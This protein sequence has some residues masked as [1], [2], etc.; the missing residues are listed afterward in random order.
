MGDEMSDHKNREDLCDGASLVREATRSALER[1]HRQGGSLNRV[2]IQ[3]DQGFIVAKGAQGED[4]IK[5]IA[6]AGRSLDRRLSEEEAQ[7]LYDLDYRRYNA[8][9]PY[10]KEVSIDGTEE[11]EVLV[12]ELLSLMVSLYAS[13]LNTIAVH[14]HF[15]D[16]LEVSNPR[17]IEAMRRL[18]KERDLSSRQKMYWAVVR[19]DV[20]LALDTAPPQSLKSDRGRSQWIESGLKEVSHI[21]D[22]ISLRDFKE[23]TSY[24][25]AAIFTDLTALEQVDPRGLHYVLLPGRLAVMIALAQG[26][27]SLLINPRSEVGGELYRNE[28]E[29]IRDGLKQLGW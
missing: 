4:E 21:S 12:D 15:G 5:L 17:L 24:R 2:I 18:S 9:R 20:L 26:W 25:S 23:I 19:A 22:S 16:E 14:E 1:I 27:S 11:R 29:S 8:A 6:A 3:G 13:S 10:V 7:Q 28:L